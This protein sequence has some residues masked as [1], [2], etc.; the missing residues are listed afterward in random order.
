MN[1]IQQRFITGVRGIPSEILN[2]NPYKLKRH[3]KDYRSGG[4][5]FLHRITPN[6]FLCPKS[7]E[8]HKKYNNY[9]F[10]KIHFFEIYDIIKP[11]GIVFHDQDIWKLN[12]LE[13]FEEQI[14]QILTDPQKQ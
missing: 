2:K 11:F 14:K 1:K 9:P 3:F 8:W 4:Y 5:I 12:D 6:G 13:S 10:C 7:V